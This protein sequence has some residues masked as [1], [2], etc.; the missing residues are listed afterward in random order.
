MNYQKIW[1]CMEELFH[2]TERLQQE[3]QELRNEL[4]SAQQSSSF[5]ANRYTK[6]SEGKKDA[7]TV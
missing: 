6:L 5:W 1:G 4:R 3:N 7:E 2:E